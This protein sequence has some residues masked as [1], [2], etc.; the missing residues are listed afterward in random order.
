VASA[1][2]RAAGGSVADAGDATPAPP[3]AAEAAVRRIE[4]RDEVPLRGLRVD[5]K[6]GDWLLQGRGGVAVVSAAKGAIVDFGPE[7][8]EDA[9]V[10]VEPAVFVGLD[11][12]PSIVESVEPAGEGGR[13]VLI[14]RRIL[15]DPPL[16]LWSYVTFADGALRIES[17]ASATDQASLAVTV[18]E[19]VAWGNVP[20]WVEGHGFVRGKATVSGDFLAREGLG[21]SYALGTETGHVVARF[22]QP[23]S[24]F[25]EWARTGERVESVP[26]H[27]TSGR[28]TVWVTQASGRLG[29]AVRALPQF[30]HE[31]AD[32][33]PLPREA[34]EDTVAE[35]ARCDGAP[36]ARFDGH[37]PALV[38][39]RGCWR[40]RLT[41]A[42]HAPGGWVSPEALAAAPSER[43]LPKASTLRWRVRQ[44]G[45]GMVP[46]RVLVRGLDGTPDPDWGEDPSDGASLN[47]VH[48]GRDGQRAIPPGRY[49][50]TV[51]RG[52]EYTMRES[53]VTAVEGKTV[54]VDAE[55]ERVVDTPGWI[56]ADLHV[57]AVASPD[58]P[59]RLSDRVLALA[60]AGVEVAVAT[61]HNAVTDYAPA[62][63]EQGLDPWLASAVGD[64]VTT[65]GV[66]FGHFNV[67]PLAPGSD[68]IAFERVTPAAIVAAARAAAPADRAKIVQLNHPRMGS[69]GYFDLTR[70]DPRDVAGWRSRSPVVDTSFDA[71]EV[72][73][74]DD[75]SNLE[76]VERVMRDWYALLDAGVRI[77]ATG[78]S[79]SHKITYHESGVPRNLVQVG[80]DDPAHFDE[81]RFVGAIRAGRVIVSSG[82]TV[83]LEVAGHGVGDSASPGDREVR[84]IV[85]APAWVDVSRVEL[86]RRGEVMHTWTVP[87]SAGPRRLDVRI[88]AVLSRGDWVLAIARGERPMAFLAR[89]GAK[90]FSFTNPVWIE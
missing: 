2:S 12:M 59:T 41:A 26:A 14:G 89:P 66:L 28:R 51:T 46:A 52:F 83:W 82:P 9:L 88:H 53:D 71:I 34:P 73:N 68:P 58:A 8:G 30:A 38:L 36:F 21:V 78:N 25:H 17:L 75:Y 74:G 50:V 81:A 43:I 7:G 3:A 79:D 10:S 11:Q 60:A 5:A 23:Q 6:K 15:S 86:V 49:R 22:A 63:R 45:A 77:T 37:A 16:R 35:V 55:L 67:F 32:R 13:S 44:K 85:D 19:V 4:S 70:F 18:G 80:D 72:F 40:A 90:P 57:H 1:C 20:T 84:V 64:E 39:S 47:V 87:F 65:R 31:P 48:A 56:A 69:I 54:V 24:G 27:G 62:I 29:E 33:Y 76:E 61:D 42:G